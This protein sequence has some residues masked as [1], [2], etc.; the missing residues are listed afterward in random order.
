MLDCNLDK[1]LQPTDGRDGEEPHRQPAGLLGASVH[2]YK[3]SWRPA[4]RLL[5]NQLAAEQRG[6]KRV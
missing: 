1:G 3:A 6:Q 2:D 4:R 5:A